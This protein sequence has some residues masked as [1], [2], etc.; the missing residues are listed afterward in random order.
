MSLTGRTRYRTGWFGWIILQVE[1][2]AL[3]AHEGT[4]GRGTDWLPTGRKWRD[5]KTEDFTESSVRP[6]FRDAPMPYPG[7]RPQT[8]RRPLPDMVPPAPPAPP[9]GR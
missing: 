7:Q 8:E 4:E 3:Q 6:L 2:T 1:E 5:A 9:T